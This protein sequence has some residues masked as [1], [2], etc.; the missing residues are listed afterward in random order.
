MPADTLPSFLFSIHK[1]LSE[2]PDPRRKQGRRYRQDAMLMLLVLGFLRGL[3]TIQ[4]ILERF[5]YDK[6]VLDYLDFKRTPSQ[7]T[8]SL[9][10]KKLPMK[11]V[12]DVLRQVG[13]QLGFSS[14]HF[15]VDGKTIKGSLH[16]DK[17]MHVVNITTPAGIPISQAK[18]E[19]AGGEITSA[20]R[21][22]KR[23]DLK[24]R[25][26]TGDAL[27]AQRKLCRAVE[28]KGAIG[29]SN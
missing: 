14:S 11:A 29:F 21:Q 26:V 13:V 7:G 3:T 28:K 9:L 20:L 4:E 2:M 27:Y 17:R 22:I 15:A 10:F 1:Q 16:R 23:L 25:V 19:L 6:D 24:G 5:S 12:N 18:S 8:Y